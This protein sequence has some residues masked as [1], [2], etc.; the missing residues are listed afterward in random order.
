M[1]HGRSRKMPIGMTFQCMVV[2]GKQAVFIVVYRRGSDYVKWWM[3]LDFLLLLF[4]QP[5][6][7]VMTF[8]VYEVIMGL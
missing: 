7:K 4:C 5:K 1:N 3:D 2:L 8:F 6:V